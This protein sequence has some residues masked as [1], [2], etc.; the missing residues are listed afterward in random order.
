MPAESANIFQIDGTTAVTETSTVNKGGVIRHAGNV[1]SDRN[2]TSK[3]IGTLAGASN[4]FGSTVASG[5]N[6][7]RSVTG[8]TPAFGMNK[9]DAQ[10]RMVGNVDFDSTSSNRN[11][12]TVAG[13]SVTAMRGG[14]SD[15]GQ[16]RN[17]AS[18]TQVRTVHTAEATRDGLWN[19]F[20]IAGQRNN[21]ESA[22][23]TST[24][25]MW[26]AAANSAAAA[27]DDHAAKSTMGRP[28]QSG[29]SITIHHGRLGKPTNSDDDANFV[30]KA[31]HGTTS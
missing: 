19:E 10:I 28:D 15:F 3:D 6:V 16:R 31:K 30:Y 29:G 18:V 13:Q 17:V 1:A 24:S 25:G 26:D 20:G 12:F 22:P 4:V 11:G 21:W 7:T 14:A 27:D 23:T 2:I 5:T 9:A 8:D